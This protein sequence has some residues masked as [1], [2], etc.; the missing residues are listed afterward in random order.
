MKQS[1]NQVDN[2][3]SLRQM[4]AIRLHEYGGP[5][6]LRYEDA[7]LPAL[8]P[9]EVLVRVHA[10]GINPPDWYLREGYKMLPAGWRPSISLPVI[11]GSDVSGVVE[12][13]ASDVQ[14][15]SPGD[16]V[17]GMIRFP[18]FGESAAYAEYVAAPASDFA[19][20]PGGIDHVQAAAAP[21]AGLTAWQFLIELGHN[22]PNPLQTEMHQP[23]PLS[24]KTVLVNGAAG[25]VGHFAVQLAKW[26]GAHVIAVASGKHES[27]LRGLGA[28][29]IID[30]KKTP[31]E[32]VVRDVDLVLDTLGGPTTGRFLRTLKGGGA[33]FPVFLG[34]SDTEE[35]A[36][37]GIT[38]S[39]TQVRSSGS[40][41]MELG[42]LMDAGT[43]RVAIDSTFP[44]ADAQK[45][46]E[47][48]AHGHI[49]GK[50]VLKVV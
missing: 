26:K 46:H 1:E 22:E 16:E 29:E 4:K 25:G 41:L 38:V 28:D 27:F 21:M 32:D 33:L 7:P 15:F 18:S 17:F 31:P 10:V 8:K 36:K 45:A 23:V 30:Y 47:R 34:F 2:T 20:K 37:L 44:L 11:P 35:A 49:Q 13:V 3:E 50:I 48:A 6:V 42:R 24:G 9:G 43:V 14:G 12:A 19:H 40:Q 5:E 39:M